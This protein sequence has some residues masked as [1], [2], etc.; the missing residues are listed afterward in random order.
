MR[1]SRPPDG[2]V[3]LLGGAY[4]RILVP[5]VQAAELLPPGKWETTEGH[6]DC[7]LAALVWLQK[8]LSLDRMELRVWVCYGV[9]G[10]SC[11][12]GATPLGFATSPAV[13]LLPSLQM[14]ENG[15]LWLSARPLATCGHLHETQLRR[16]RAW[17]NSKL[18]RTVLIFINYLI[19]DRYSILNAQ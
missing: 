8:S 9:P 14:E 18:N 2:D 3:Q 12:P 7:S 6:C 4:P 1:G 15:C 10:E 11:P 19:L 16:Q 13:L 17:V 5:P